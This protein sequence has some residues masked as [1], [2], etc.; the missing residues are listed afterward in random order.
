MDG[1]VKLRGLRIELGEIEAVATRHE[2]IRQFVAA[3][4]SVGG[5]DQLVGYYAVK[6]GMEVSPDELRSFMAEDL[7]EFMIPATVMRLDKMPMTPNGKIDR[8]A[9]PLPEIKL[10]EDDFVKAETPQEIKITGIVSELLG[11]NAFGVTTNLLKTG[12]TSLLA[13]RLVATIAKRMNVRI[14]SKEAMADPTVRGIVKAISAVGADVPAAKTIHKRKY[15]PITE[16]Q[17]GVLIDWERNRDAVQY[18]VPQAIKLKS[19]TDLNR[20]RDAL[21]ATV[22][23]HPALSATF[24]NR[25]GDVMQQRRDIGN[26]L[27]A[28]LSLDSTP[29]RGQMQDLVRPFDLFADPLYRFTI[30]RTPQGDWLFMDFHHI[31]FDGVSAMVFFDSLAKAY[32]G[33]CLQEEEYSALN[34]QPMRQPSCSRPNTRRPSNGSTDC[35]TASRPQSTPTVPGRKQSHRALYFAEKL[36]LTEP[37]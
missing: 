25:N 11:H 36:R 28:E 21:T 37:A 5:N 32:A 1:M 16:N 13:M 10:E 12:L 31:V 3:V 26:V 34:G 24:V 9:L 18:N 22:K 15:Y 27:V 19:D 30:I 29:S 35:L 4:K 14:T 17:R 8:R 6:D 20:L 7:T 23:A 33:E 2:A